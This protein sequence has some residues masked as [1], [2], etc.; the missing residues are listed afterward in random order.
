MAIR[1]AFFDLD[2]TL[3]ESRRFANRARAAAVRAM[4]REGAPVSE[5]I[6]RSELERA[7]KS[8]G[9]NYPR[10]FNRVLAKLKVANWPR[11]AAAGVIAYHAEKNRMRLAPGAL[12]AL[13][14]LRARRMKVYIASEG[15]PVKQ[16]DKLIRLGLPNLIDGVFVSRKKSKAFFS[17]SL[18]KA[19][20]LP[21][22]AVM[23]G[24][25]L[26]KDALPALDAGMKAVLV[27]KGARKPALGKTK[28]ENLYY[29]DSIAELPK[30]L[31]SFA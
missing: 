23:V 13:E 10:H 7:V 21:G 12:R 8:Y 27:G 4:V 28:N 3:Y 25:R 11:Y 26:E 22:E 1:A 6:L 19:G 17:R 5:G 2:D 29:A 14:K 16:W 9:S 20:I 18:K 31:E 24:D 30:L 15:V